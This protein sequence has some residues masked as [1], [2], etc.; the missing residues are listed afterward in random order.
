MADFKKQIEED[1]KEYQEKYG[2]T[3]SDINKDEWAF[4]F[5]V[6]DKF[7]Y[8]D[9][10]LIV[11]KVTDYSDYGIDAYEWYEDTK[12]LYLIQNK[13]YSAETKLNL[14]Y[15]Q[16]TFLVTPL[17][18]L[19][20][21]KYTKCKE[22]Q[23]VYLKYC[24]DE[25]YSIHLQMYITNDL[26]D[27][28]AVDAVKEFNQKHSPQCTAEIFYLSDIEEKWY[29]EPKKQTK[30]FSTAIESVNN[31]TILN[32][33]NEAYH[34]ANKIDAKY[35]FVPVTCL[36]RMVKAANEKK[37]EL[38]EKNIREYLGN[39]RINKKIYLTLKDE[40][41][42]KN[43]FYYNNGITMICSKMGTVHSAK[44]KSKNP[45]VCVSF[46]IDNPQIVNGCQTV[47]SIFSAL[48]EY[49]EEDLE[50]EFQDTF[51]MLKILQIDAAD[52]TQKAL[53]KNIV[54]YNNSQNSLDEKQF[55]ANNELFQR[56]KSEFGEKGFLL[57]TKQ[58]DKNIN[59]VNY[60]KRSDLSKLQMASISRRTLFG[61]ESLK[62]VSDFEIQLEK[63]L[64]VI[65]A[66]KVGGLAAYTMKKDVLKPD[67][68]SYTT[69]IEFIK[70]SNVTTEALLN[71]YLLY[72]RFEKEKNVNNIQMI[73]FYAIDGFSRF[74]CDK[75]VKQMTEYFKSEKSISRIVTVYKVAC[76]EYAK[77]YIKQQKTDYTKMIKA[78]IDYD[79]FQTN[80]SSAVS[81]FEMM[82]P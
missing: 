49:D 77:S 74:E 9:E 8:E 24:N 39:N 6:L 67:K 28:K 11:D 17:A 35:V 50:R 36:Y 56:L 41:E 80:H 46:E 44:N 75:N 31:G 33:N 54:T 65:L 52:E 82:N 10:E 61:L 21:G 34:L 14:S 26:R 57:L 19:K 5:W 37:Y 1:I 15:V 16:N 62:K 69:V 48:K 13:F 20:D 73:P 7:F 55:V 58:S 45:H 63:L 40:Q 22:L 23:D 47:N 76:S 72:L 43:F 60:K 12:E 18:V 70:S 4:N 64:Q 51:V 59:A 38:F 71:L 79:L 42:R 3:L 78:E 53:A 68:E 66:F 29:G 25:S 81:M 30:T 32:I 27:A 2:R